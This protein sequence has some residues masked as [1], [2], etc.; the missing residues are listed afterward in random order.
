VDGAGLRPGEYYE[1]VDPEQLAAVLDELF[2]D[3]TVDATPDG[4]VRAVARGKR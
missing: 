2:S 3:V 4:D 1:N